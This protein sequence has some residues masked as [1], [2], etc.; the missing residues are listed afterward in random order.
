M[1]APIFSG[2]GRSSGLTKR[3][4]RSGFAARNARKARPTSVPAPTTMR[5]LPEE[6]EPARR[7]ARHVRGRPADGVD[8]EEEDARHEVDEALERD[9][10]EA[11]RDGKARARARATGRT[12]SPARA[13]RSVEAAKPME[14]AELRSY[15]DGLPAFFRRRAQRHER[16]RGVCKEA[17]RGG[18]DEP[19]DVR[20]ADRLA[21]GGEVERPEKEHEEDGREAERHR[22]PQ[23]FAALFGGAH[24][25][26]VAHTCGTLAPCATC[27]S[28]PIPSFSSTTPAPTTPRTPDGSRPWF[29]R[30]AQEGR[31]F[32]SPPDPERTLKALERVHEPAYVARLK[33]ACD[34]AP[35]G[36]AAPFSLFDCPDNPI[37]AAT[38][39]AAYRATGLVLAA[40]D[41]VLEK[42]A[43]A[44]FVAARPPGHHALAAQAMGFCFFNTIAVAARDLVEH[45]GATRVL[46]ADFDVHHGNGT[47]Q[48]FWEDGRVAYLSVH[49]YPFYPGTGA[50][51]EKGAGKGRGATVN[52]PQ[53]A[54][55]G[56]GAYAGGFSA[57]LE[58]LAERFKPEFVLISAGFDAHEGDPLG[59]MGVTTAGFAWM[60][61]VAGGGRRDLRRRADRV[62]SRGRVRRASPGRV[63]GRARARS[64]PDGRPAVAGPRVNGSFDRAFRAR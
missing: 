56:D 25:R 24:R 1:R 58:T 7:F 9:R 16:K 51:D 21:H 5:E 11:R 32:E 54:G 27:R 13:G 63:G 15:A 6:H 30:C 37:S 50:A 53:R 49:R 38:F 52:V 19:A 17:A 40:V 64:R 36:G 55:A 26:I 34:A 46:V 4:V 44:V 12:I 29:T 62:A 60:T 28:S 45:S 14:V 23:R 20:A 33:A 22:D 3:S 31:R 18:E 41:A 48:I 57:A 43:P 35:P 47:Q 8:D 2:S 10:R 59:G 61:Q 39:A 42:R